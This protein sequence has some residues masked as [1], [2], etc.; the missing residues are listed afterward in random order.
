[1]IRR[2]ELVW[3]RVQGKNMTLAREMGM[4][5]IKNV[6]WYGR[7]NVYKDPEERKRRAWVNQLTGQTAQ[8]A[9]TEYITGGLS[10]YREQQRIAG[11]DHTDHGI[12]I[13]PNI[14]VKS[15]LMKRKN[16][17][18]FS[19]ELLVNAAEF[20]HDWI[21][22]Y[23]QVHELNTREFARVCIVGW[24]ESRDIEGRLS[25]KRSVPEG[26]LGIPAHRLRPIRELRDKWE[27][28]HGRS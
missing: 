19:Q 9:A 14:D 16:T 8:L 26:C 12:D 25:K 13:P 11:R 1:M 20:H 2:R 10:V 3:R 23:C 27:V 7:S 22:V 28:D 24:C 6:G 21:Y 18:P 5:V 15:G 4:R 17:D